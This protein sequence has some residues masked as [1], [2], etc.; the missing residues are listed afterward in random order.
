MFVPPGRSWVP[1]RA[2][3]RAGTRRCLPK[4][5]SADGRLGGVFANQKVRDRRL[6]LDPLRVQAISEASKTPRL[7][8]RQARTPCGCQRSPGGGSAAPPVGVRQT[9]EGRAAPALQN[10]VGQPTLGT[11]GSRRQTAEGNA[12]PEPSIPWA[13]SSSPFEANPRIFKHRLDCPVPS[14]S[15]H[16]GSNCAHRKQ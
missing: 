15:H 6:V 8:W 16:D 10:Q 14:I 12:P 2:K 7:Q 1:T 4:S 13:L 5:K 9:G 3:F 11:A